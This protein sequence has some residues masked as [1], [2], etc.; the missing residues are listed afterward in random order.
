MAP[1]TDPQASQLVSV[2]SLATDPQLS[3]MGANPRHLF[4]IEIGASKQ[5]AGH[6]TWAIR[7]RGKL[8][9]RSDT[10]Y[11]SEGQARVVALA[12]LDRLQG[13]RPS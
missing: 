4:T 10:P 1:S 3:S 6:Y 2:V 13:G 9:R 7:D 8:F 11:P 5:G 12:E